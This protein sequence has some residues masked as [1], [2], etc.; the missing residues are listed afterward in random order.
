MSS[1]LSLL[2]S[3]DAVERAIAE[4]D[5]LGRDVFLRKYGFNYS[6]KYPLTHAGGTYDSKAIVAAAYGYQH[7]EPLRGRDFSG[8]KDTV[9]PVLA[10][11]GFQCR[12]VTH[13]AYE[14]VPGATYYRKDL[15]DTFGG[16]LQRGI[17]TPK[18]FSAV[19]LF[20]GKS[21]EEFGYE[22]GWTPSGVFQ[23][24][25]EGQ[26]GDMVF[27]G[28]NC[29][30]RDHRKAGRDLLLFEDLGKGKGVRYVGLFDCASWRVVDG[31]DRTGAPRK[32][33]IFDLVQVGSAGVS[34]EVAEDASET[35]RQGSIDELRRAALES[36]SAGGA[37][38]QGGEAKRTWRARSE[39]VRVYVW[40]CPYQTRQLAAG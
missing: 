36:S 21:G 27:E 16:Q 5:S 14:L 4:C 2:T 23:Y 6:R 34:G 8:D 30:I 37:L 29:A 31:R 1:K 35:T 40:S 18:E 17:W 20:S 33:I 12:H 11:L 22:D 32:I 39:A 24:T 28:G 15:L 9:L 26:V 38:P 7:G 10:R 3:R 25:G 19:L 13:P